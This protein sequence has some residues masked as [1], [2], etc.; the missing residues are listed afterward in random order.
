MGKDRE[1]ERERQTDRQSRKRERGYRV[2]FLKKDMNNHTGWA[3]VWRESK[4]RQTAWQGVMEK[5][6]GGGG[7]ELN[8]GGEEQSNIKSALSLSLLPPTPP[9]Q[10]PGE[11]AT[12]VLGSCV[13]VCL[14]RCAMCEGTC[15]ELPGACCNW[16]QCQILFFLDLDV[17]KREKLLMLS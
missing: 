15:A 10:S 2:K 16:F 17:L 12:R 6:E 8:R 13:C 1:R 11:E 4:E 7:G 9:T 5:L 14:C 3:N